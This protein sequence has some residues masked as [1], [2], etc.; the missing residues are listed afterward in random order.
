MG[1]KNDYKNDDI[2]QPRNASCV[3][4]GVG[5]TRILVLIEDRGELCKVCL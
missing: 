3:Q 4:V 2:E 5:Q 1:N